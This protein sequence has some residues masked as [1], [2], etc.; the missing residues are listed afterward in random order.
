MRNFSSHF[1]SLLKPL[2][3]AGIIAISAVNFSFGQEAAP[4]DSSATASTAPS[5][6]GGPAGDAAAGEALFKSNCGACHAIDKRVLGPALAG[7]NQKQSNEWL[8]KWIKNSQGLIASGDKDAV[9]I[10]EEF[11]KMAM[12]AF[13]QLSDA[14]IDNILAYV[15]EAGAKKPE[16][17]TAA[18]GA[19]AA[20]EDTGVSSF[21]IIGLVAVVLIAFLV[22]VVLNRVIGTLERLLVTK[23]AEQNVYVEDEEAEAE[24]KDRFRVV[25]QLAKNKKFVFFVVLALL[26]TLG[27]FGYMDMWN[28]GVQ[29]GYQPVQPIKFSHQLHAG[30]N[31]IDCQYCHS[32]AWKSKNATIPSLNICM[33][34]HKYVQA[35]DKYNGEISPEIQKIYTALDYNPETQ[36]YGNNTR[37]IEWVRIHNLPDLAYFNHSQHVSVAGIECQ[38]CHGPIQ[39]MEEVYQ[40]SPLTMKWCI[41]CHK[42][43]EVNSKGNAYY[44]KVIAAHDSIKKGEKVTAAVLGGLECGKCHY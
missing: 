3:L 30:T 24:E 33:N 25:K 16:A 43:T 36:K 10:F 2:A 35:T 14:D 42:E 37:P 38:K 6:G 40:Y 34:C 4:A 26:I 5:A 8:H 18:G 32:G 15:E 28:T 21:M 41:N 11:N 31:Q 39:E 13:P 19:T 20:A 17:A 12:P 23:E 27:S 1:R 29:T 9:A 22:I 7:I 44:D